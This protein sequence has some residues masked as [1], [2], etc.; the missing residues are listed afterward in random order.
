MAHNFL[1][2]RF[3]L[4]CVVINRNHEVLFFAGPTEDYLVQP[5]GPPTHDLLALARPGLESNLRVLIQRAIRDNAPQ[6]IK[7]VLIH[8]AGAVR[9]VSLDAEPLGRSRQTEGLLLVAFQEQ[10]GPAGET[11]AEAKA[12]AQTTDSDL[13]R[14]LEQ[15]LETTREDL[16]GTVEE[17]E[18]SNEELKASNEEIMSMNEELQSTNE[19]LETSKEELHSLNEELN[20]VNGQLHE[21][22]QELETA[23]NDIANLLNCT[24]IATV[25][26]DA[27]FRIK[28]YTPAATRLFK[29]IRT[30]VGRPL[31]EVVQRFTDAELPG[32]VQQV[33]RDPT[34]QEKE[35]R[36]EDG[37][38]YLRRVVPYR[39]LDERLDGVV[40]TFVDITERKQAAD[41]VVRQLAAIV[42]NSADAIFS[43]DL[44]GTIR[45]WNRGAERLYGYGRDEAVGRSVQIFVPEDRSE[46]WDDVMARL[47]RGEH[48]E[49]LETERLCKH[50]R[51]AVVA[52]TVSPI[53][54]EGGKV[55]SASVI[56]RD[57]SE[58]KQAEQ[59]LRDRE[60]RLQAILGTVTDAVITI[61]YQ[62]LIQGVN[63]AAERMFGYAAAEMVGQSVSLLMPAPYR[64]EHAGYLVRYFKTGIRHVI[65][66]SREV[67]ARR[68]DGT[69]FPVELGV[70][71]LEQLKLF[72]GIHRDLTAR[73][74]LERD[75]VEVASLE[76]RRIGQ[77]LHDTVGQELTA[78]N[79]LAGELAAALRS[80]PAHAALLVERIGQGLQRSQ[81]ELRTV[82]RGL[83]P[84][85]VDSEGLMAALTDLA[86]RTQQERKATCTFDCPEPVSVADN[87]TATHLYLIA[88]EAVHNALKH[89]RPRNVRIR[90]ESNH[91]MIL[92]VQDDGSGM[93]AG[94]G[95]AQGLG[96]RIMRNRAAIIG[97]SL[98]I[99]PGTPT[100]T[101][102]TCTLVRRNHERQKEETRPGPD[103][104]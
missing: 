44:D 81:Q 84:V 11:P 10:P 88:Q 78:L 42:E 96:L 34:L 65:G 17:L 38:W 87:V 15:E 49:Q 53:R 37:R 85:A 56:A 70:S 1:L 46:E 5:A 16:Q 36:T 63:R 18:S 80:D 69:V 45:T 101:V 74:Q 97:A 23:N 21:K 20:T 50:G 99:E 83:L 91:L 86:F 58:R 55:V 13:V 3:A 47:A 2:R 61:D 60:E 68:K 93:P 48:V 12:R 73:R 104:R 95:P 103:R 6:S 7:D 90:L 79:L 98:T 59:A 14:H 75:V 27:D 29:L 76:Q 82:L 100:G 52:L 39:T 72:V 32:D 30:D 51:R 89:A 22:V 40:V 41:A 8:R 94:P 71:E 4:A 43:K 102:V 9:R 67:E 24:D 54:D 57:I 64:E 28:R 62:G 77:D 92:R 19:E 25:F 35:V 26:L 31:D 66:T 33:L